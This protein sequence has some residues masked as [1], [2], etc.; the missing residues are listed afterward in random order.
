MWVLLLNKKYFCRKCVI[1]KS[2]PSYEETPTDLTPEMELVMK[3]RDERLASVSDSEG[4]SSSSSSSSYKSR[5]RTSQDDDY[6]PDS[7][8][9]DSDDSVMFPKSFWRSTTPRN[10][11]S[12]ADSTSK[13]NHII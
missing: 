6:E 3:R 7:D 12:K 13:T 2:F 1:L 5:R 4:Y 10:T 11:R 8:S 9:D